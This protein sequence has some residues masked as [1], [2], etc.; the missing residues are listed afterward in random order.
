MKV[1]AHETVEYEIWLTQEE[2]EWLKAYMQNPAEE[3]EDPVTLT[4]R[5]NLFRA[6][7]AKG[8]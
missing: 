3:V 5:E 4:N 6:L 7:H 8:V 2:A 1:I